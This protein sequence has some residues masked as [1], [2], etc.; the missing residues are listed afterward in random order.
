[1][2]MVEVK[3]MVVDGLEISVEITYNK[4]GNVENVF[5]VRED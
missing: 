3:K 5:F 4:S 1:M 2:K